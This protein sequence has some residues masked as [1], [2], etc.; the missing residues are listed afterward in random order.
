MKYYN[1]TVN[2]VAYSVSVEET[3]AGAA[4]VAAPAAPVAAPAAPAA[5]PKA[6]APAGA[7][8]AVAVK[9]PMPGNIL[10]V[11]VAAGASV[12][13]GDVLVILEAMK[14]ENE[15]VAPQDGTV[16]SVNVNKGDTVNSG[17][18]LV[19]MN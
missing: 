1:I 10:D 16:A 9:A 15:I 17:D 18:V 3:A 6:A 8:G 13:A 2:G 7:A 14:M 5:A 4:P 11:K 12:K 19:S